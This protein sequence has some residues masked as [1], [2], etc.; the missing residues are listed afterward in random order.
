[1]NKSDHHSSHEL[2]RLTS[3]TQLMM[4][5]EFISMGLLYSTSILI[6]RFVGADGYGLY[7]LASVVAYI[8][9]LLGRFGLDYTVMR[10]SGYFRGKNQPNHEHSAV[11]IAVFVTVMLSSV[12]AIVLY[13]LAPL[14]STAIFNKPDMVKIVRWF[15][16]MLPVSNLIPIFTSIFLARGQVKDKIML[17]NI[18]FPV[19]KFILIAL[20]FTI[21]FRMTGLMLAIAAATLAAVVVGSFRLQKQNRFAMLRPPLPIT[22]K[23]LRFGTPVLGEGLLSYISAWAELLMLGYFA[24][25]NDVGVLGVI[26]RVTMLVV[27]VQ[28]TFNGIF[29]PIIAELHGRDNVP[30]I[31][32]LLKKQTLWSFSAALPLVMLFVGFSHDL[33]GIWGNAFVGGAIALAIIAFGRLA[34]AAVG[35]V[36][37]L[38]MM[39]GKPKVNTVN[40]LI[41]LLIKIGAGWFLIPRYGLLGAAIL[42]AGANVLIDVLRVIEVYYFFRIHPFSSN[43]LKPLLAVMI[44]ALVTWLW[45][46][47]LS[48][49]LPHVVM[50]ATSGVVFL[51][52]YLVALLK[53]D[54]DLMAFFP[55]WRQVEAIG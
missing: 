31:S 25:A 30:A 11:Q 46:I 41:I 27:F 26:I 13:I 5:G 4:A 33:M 28:Y 34:D 51:F 53:L 40:S 54:I 14:I 2:L 18:L 36:G 47:S 21:G 24:H 43:F 44:G 20:L 3:G 32:S 52:V 38:L 29:S 16:F 50:V 17:E 19:V 1:M 22:G 23:L 39:M 8:A 35:T 37:M 55:K 42:M 9:S 7:F 48:Q 15:A 6:S 45:H 49:F 12:V 10:F